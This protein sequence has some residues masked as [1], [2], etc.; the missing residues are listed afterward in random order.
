VERVLR[1]AYF[2][3]LID[4]EGNIAVQRQ[5]KNGY[6]R[7]IIEVKMTCETTILALRTHFGM[8]HITWQPG[9]QVGWKPSWR[10]RVTTRSARLVAEVIR[11]YLITKADALE[12]CFPVDENPM[13]DCR[14][15]GR[16]Y[17]SRG[18]IFAS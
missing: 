14:G 18:G 3:G 6:M 17:A 2:A 12:R 11:P 8:G 7:P 1:D 13:D 16:L 5:G 10:W 15:R 9:D 4:G